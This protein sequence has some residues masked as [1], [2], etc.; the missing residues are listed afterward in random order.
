MGSLPPELWSHI[1]LF[2]SPTDLADLALS[3]KS[4]L[5]SARRE[6]YHT[7]VLDSD[8]RSVQE[9][10]KLLT[11]DIHLCRQVRKLILITSSGRWYPKNWP[12][13]EFQTWFDP[14]IFGRMDAL[15]TI[16][17]H[18]WP[19][20]NPRASGGSDAFRDML[21]A[22]YTMSRSLTSVKLENVALPAEIIFT[23][24]KP[25][26]HLKP[27]FPVLPIIQRV[28]FKVTHG[29]GFGWSFVL[30]TF[31]FRSPS[32]IEYL[33]L[34]FGRYTP[35]FEALS[36]LS[37]PRL[38]TLHFRNL[39]R[40]ASRHMTTF[41]L[42]HPSLRYVHLLQCDLFLEVGRLNV[43]ML[44]DLHTISASPPLLLSLGQRC[45][46]L[47][48]IRCLYI[49]CDSVEFELNEYQHMVNVTRGFPNLRH[50]AVSRPLRNGVHISELMAAFYVSIEL[51][52]WSGGFYVRDLLK[53]DSIPEVISIFPALARLNICEWT[54]PHVPPL[55][56][57]TH[58]RALNEI[59]R[60]GR[61]LKKIALYQVHLPTNEISA[62]YAVAAVSGDATVGPVPGIVSAG[63]ATRRSVSLQR[64]YQYVEGGPHIKERRKVDFASTDW[65]I[66]TPLLAAP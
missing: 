57:A 38:R 42:A 17:F 58:L 40:P 9:T 47:R 59:A 23:N 22:I 64:T 27:D 43:N 35:H 20:G 49:D 45:D 7:V 8:G 55:S 31:F 62:V 66:E 60:A 11:K 51:E 5:Q 1:C 41:L 18:G 21:C 19:A 14:A 24:Y 50:I 30:P 48:Y 44:P 63:A 53:M 12:N 34:S 65:Q 37:F 4:L 3:S 56:E 54:Y 32:P 61:M 46:S 15:H 10:V 25:T 52:C 33:D 2:L 39:P 36:T 13:F 29:G 16:H 26:Q 6:L 28:T